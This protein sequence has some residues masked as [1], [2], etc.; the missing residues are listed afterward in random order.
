MMFVSL[1]N[2]WQWCLCHC[3]ICNNDVC[4]IVQCVTMMFVSLCN[5]WQWCLCHCAMCDNGLNVIVQCVTMM[6][7]SLCNVWQWCLCH[8][9]VCDNDV[10][11]IV[12]YVL[13]AECKTAVT[14]LLM[15][16]SYGILALSPWNF[17][18][19]MI[20]WC[21]CCVHLR[22]LK[23]VQCNKDENWEMMIFCLLVL[24]S[25]RNDI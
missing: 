17:V 2:V 3:A 19:M 8:C 10:C 22:W 12:Q 25:N 14:P 18:T 1:C 4:I 6:F 21:R 20:C 11:V 5:V 15:H 13:M 16:R 7:M 23:Y 24:F 9:A